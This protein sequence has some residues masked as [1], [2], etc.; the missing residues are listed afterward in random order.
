M[1]DLDQW[2]SDAASKTAGPV[3]PEMFENLD[4][5]MRGE[6]S[7]Q[8]ISMRRDARWTMACACVAALFGFAVTGAT[9]AFA[10][11][12]PTWLAAPSE[13]SPYSLLVGR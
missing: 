1:T 12:S 10:K 6:T 7:P 13:A 4:R 9:G 3:S 2:L 11:P 8:D 5:R